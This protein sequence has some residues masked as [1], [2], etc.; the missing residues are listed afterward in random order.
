MTVAELLEILKDCDRHREVQIQS[1]IGS[2]S[3]EESIEYVSVPITDK[4]I[5]LKGIDLA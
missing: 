3:E 5:V 4:P 2:Y 1:F